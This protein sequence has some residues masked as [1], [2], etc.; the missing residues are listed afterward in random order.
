M[1]RYPATLRASE[2]IDD[3]DGD[4]NLDLMV[5]SGIPGF[6]FSI[7]LGN[8][9]GTFKPVQTFTPSVANLDPNSSHS[10]PPM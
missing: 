3:L 5:S 7:F 8:G 10:S 1:C 6:S 2:V 4:G 9:N